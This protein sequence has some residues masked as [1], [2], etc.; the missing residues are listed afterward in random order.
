MYLCWYVGFDDYLIAVTGYSRKGDF[1]WRGPGLGPASERYREVAKCDCS[2]MRY[3]TIPSRNITLYKNL[4][5]SINHLRVT[6]FVTKHD[7]M[8]IYISSPAATFENEAVVLGGESSISQ[9]HYDSRGFEESGS[10]LT[11]E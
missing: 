7:V 8:K 6:M 3:L 5:I 11:P 2:G 9:E 1:G 10:R 4:C